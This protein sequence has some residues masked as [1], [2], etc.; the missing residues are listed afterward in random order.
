MAVL[1]TSYLFIYKLMNVLGRANDKIESMAVTDLLTGLPNHRSLM[2]NLDHEFKRCNRYGSILSVLMMDIDNFK[3][4][5]DTYGHLAG[6]RVL[7]A[8]GAILKSSVRSS[9]VTGRYGGEEFCA[10]LIETDGENAFLIAEKVRKAVENT[11]FDIGDGQPIRITL[12]I[13]IAT[14]NAHAMHIAKAEELLNLSDKALYKSKEAG[15][16]R[17][18]AYSDTV[19]A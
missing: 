16:N 1:G 8:I 5:N 6:D 9:D 2:E 18:T 10:V 15:R 3:L 7:A 19:F 11:H 14:Y 13:G 17:T 12:S 4:V